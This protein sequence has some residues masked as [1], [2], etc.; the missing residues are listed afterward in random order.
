MNLKQ[1]FTS[2]KFW[3]SLVAFATSLIV[4]FNVEGITA[5]Q[6]TLILSGIG[7]LICYIFSE[8]SVDKGNIKPIETD[9]VKAE[10]VNNSVEVKSDGGN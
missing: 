9:L 7:S 6:L 3:A 8:G 1:K 5:E 10:T 2:R 4:A